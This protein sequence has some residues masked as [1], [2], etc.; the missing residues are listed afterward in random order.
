[1]AGFTRFKALRDRAVHEL[2]LRRA[3]ERAL[4]APL[5]VLD[6]DDARLKGSGGR[7][8]R[9]RHRPSR[10]LPASEVEPYADAVATERVRLYASK[11]IRGGWAR[12]DPLD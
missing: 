3:E 12:G 5:R 8:P 2:V 6:G 7:A 4:A 9:E 11:V 1:M 10:T